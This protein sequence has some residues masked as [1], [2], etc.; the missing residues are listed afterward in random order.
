MAGRAEE[1]R[2][3]L[4]AERP[5]VLVHRHGVGG[6]VLIGETDVVL[7][8]VLLLVC[9]TDFLEGGLEQFPVLG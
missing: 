3:V 7:D 6:L 9:G 2:A 4:L 8:A 5:V 1:Q